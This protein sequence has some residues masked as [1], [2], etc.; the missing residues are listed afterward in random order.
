[1][2]PAIKCPS[3]TFDMF[4]WSQWRTKQAWVLLAILSAR[5]ANIS[6]DASLSSFVGTFTPTLP[7]TDSSILL[8]HLKL[9][10]ITKEDSKNY[11]VRGRVSWVMASLSLR[12]KMENWAG[13]T[14]WKITFTLLAYML[15]HTTVYL[16][17]ELFHW[18]FPVTMWRVLIKMTLPS[19][20][21]PLVD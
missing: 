14:D 20:K 10:N 13:N 16:S 6:W 8:P 17:W 18:L 21:S 12:R 15:V 1:M 3:A 2:A 5:V 19:I 9:T 11:L 7:L 4:I